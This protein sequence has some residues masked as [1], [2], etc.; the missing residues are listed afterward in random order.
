LN[1]DLY[2]IYDIYDD[3]MYNLWLIIFIEIYFR[4]L[5]FLILIDWYDINGYVIWIYD[6]FVKIL[7]INDEWFFWWYICV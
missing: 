2:V 6:C 7:Y 4:W 3:A 5:K 1:C